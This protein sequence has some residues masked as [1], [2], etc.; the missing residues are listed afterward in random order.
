MSEPRVFIGI[1]A[2]SGLLTSRAAQTLYTA[3]T[4]H[5]KMELVVSCSALCYS[6]NSLWCT[7]LNRR[8][9]GITHFAMLHA[10]I[11]P[12]ADW[13][14]V[15]IAEMD[16][17]DADVVSAVVPLK[18]NQGVTSTAID[19]DQWRPRRLTI[20][21]TNGLP[22]TFGAV[23]V[24]WADGRKLLVNTGCWVCKF[25]SPWIE[26]ICF[27]MRDRIIREGDKFVPQ[28]FP[29]DWHFSRQCHKEDLNVMA[30]TKVKLTHIGIAPFPN[31]GEWGDMSD[32]LNGG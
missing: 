10:D 28:F 13:I 2:Y 32:K 31:Y 6:F 27:E 22:E 11:D 30:T 18:G 5:P 7:A 16:R 9:D 26:R 12:Q 29:E 14:D 21:E 20:R 24:T 25:T 23:D 19:T 15:L 1:P 4:I 17:Y 3:S 8:S